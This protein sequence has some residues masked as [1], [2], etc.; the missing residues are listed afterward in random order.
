MTPSSDATAQPSLPERS[1]RTSSRP[2][3]WPSTRKPPSV[4][5]LEL[6]RGERGP[7]RAE[8]LAELRAE[9]RQVRL[10]VQLGRLDVAELDLLHAQLVAQLVRVTRGERRALD[11]EPTQTAGAASG[12]RPRR[13]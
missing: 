7:D 12:A 8:L 6:A 2:S 4:E 13:A 9:H 5:L 11:D 10:H 1:T 3:S